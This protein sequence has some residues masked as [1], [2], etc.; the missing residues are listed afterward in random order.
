MGPVLLADDNAVTCSALRL[1]L[2]TRLDLH[3]TVTARDW[4]S[5]EALAIH[6]Q[7]GVI[8][9]DWELPKG[10]ALAGLAALRRAAPGAR[11]VAL[12]A[13]PEARAEALGAG[14][15][16]FVAKVD[17]PDRLLDI[18]QRYLDRPAD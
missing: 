2:S 15:D 6:V 10:S 9:L 13:R 17:P 14:V 3:E 12:S 7:P 18:I 1:L 5:L 4:R 16:A 8:L 11:L